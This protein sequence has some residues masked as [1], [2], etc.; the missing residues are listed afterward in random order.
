MLLF[1]S[2]GYRRLLLYP[3]QRSDVQLCSRVHPNP[4]KKLHY[5][6]QRSS[7]M[8]NGVQDFVNVSFWGHGFDSRQQH[9]DYTESVSLL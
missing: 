1:E 5:I 7:S 3:Q 9:W 8:V 4:V 2:R 6:C